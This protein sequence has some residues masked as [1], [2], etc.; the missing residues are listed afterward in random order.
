V[1]SLV[2]AQRLLDARSWEP[3]LGAQEQQQEK[4]DVAPGG[5]GRV[6]EELNEKAP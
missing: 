4:T 1:D 3:L 2:H 6:Y 5:R